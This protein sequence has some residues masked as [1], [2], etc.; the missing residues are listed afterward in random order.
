MAIKHF[1]PTAC[2]IDHV[3]ALI[4]GKWKPMILWRLSAKRQRFGE[5]QAAMPAV[6]HKVLSQ[7]LRQLQADG[8]IRRIVGRSRGIPG[9]YELT[10][11]GRTLRPALNALAVWGK[12]HAKPPVDSAYSARGVRRA[13]TGV[14]GGASPA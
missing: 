7:Q 12:M 13:I 8:L 10:E 4:K 9:E 2:P 5:F 14:H 6:T 11:F 3:L 1:E